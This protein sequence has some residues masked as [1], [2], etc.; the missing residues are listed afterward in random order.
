MT[1]Y[2][3]GADVYGFRPTNTSLY[4]SDADYHIPGADIID[5]SISERATEY[6]D[7]AKILVNNTSGV[8]SDIID[9]GDRIELLT[10]SPDQNEGYGEGGYGVGPYGTSQ[11]IRWI[12]MIRPYTIDGKGGDIYDLD[13]TGEDYAAAIMGSRRVYATFEDRQI[14]GSNGIVNE[15]INE[16]A[17]ELNTS[18]LPSFADTTSIFIQGEFLLDVVAELSRRCDCILRTYHKSIEFIRPSEVSAEFTLNSDDYSDFSFKSNDDNL[19]NS[20]RVEGGSGFE[21]EEQAQQ[22][23]QDGYDRVTNSDRILY[24][25]D[26]RKSAV[27]RVELW[28]R[29]VEDGGDLTVRLQKNDGGSPIDVDS[30]KSDVAKKTLDPRFISNDDYTTFIFPNHTLP[31]PL[32]WIIIQSEDSVGH[33]I[34]INTSTGDP[35]IIPYYPYDIVVDI[36]DQ[37]SIDSYRLRED[38][39][40]DET[41]GS[42]AAARDEGESTVAHNN[43]P[44]E[45]FAGN[46]ESPRMHDVDPADVV[47]L[48]NPSLNVNENFVVTEVSDN[49]HGSVVERE[50]TLRDI[51]S[52]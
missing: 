8:Y 45:T 48:N 31:E 7:N 39:I 12:G 6:K 51:N 32:P 17:P 46:A 22:T 36:D 49:Y 5:V 47:A 16:N 28:T 33:D 18:Q 23:T 30:E 37:D 27:N 40:T 24:Q 44:A 10:G 35:A 34:G 26:T 15:L 3:D 2:I 13:I 38:K 19:I 52:L 14:V 50:F 41:L 1:E 21:I 25:I 42:F 4:Y 20:V 9:H 11:T 43:Q 29:K